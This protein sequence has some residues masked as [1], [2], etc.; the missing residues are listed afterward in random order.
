MVNKSKKLGIEFVTHMG[1][2]I[3][4]S[5]VEDFDPET[6]FDGPVVDENGLCDDESCQKLGY[7]KLK[8]ELDEP[9]E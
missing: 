3:P 7:C 5:A 8:K 6:H 4:K 2:Y 1:Y 9:I